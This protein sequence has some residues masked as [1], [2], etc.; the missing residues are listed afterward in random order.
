MYNS[1][2][3]VKEVLGWGG[4]PSL[5]SP[6]TFGKGKSV[7]WFPCVDSKALLVQREARSSSSHRPGVLA[8]LL[9]ERD[10]LPL[11]ANRLGRCVAC[12]YQESEPA[13]VV[14]MCQTYSSV[15]GGSEEV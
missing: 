7:S 11:L 10:L 5:P 12:C 1:I 13:S 4:T 2:P 14:P 9:E 6:P 8:V 3:A 15:W